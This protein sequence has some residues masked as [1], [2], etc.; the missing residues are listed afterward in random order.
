MTLNKGAHQVGTKEEILKSVAKDMIAMNAT[1]KEEESTLIAKDVDIQETGTTEEVIAAGILAKEMIIARIEGIPG[2]EDTKEMT[3]A[4]I[5]IEM[6]EEDSEII[7]SI[8]TEETTS[9]DAIGAIEIKD[10]PVETVRGEVAI[11]DHSA[12]MARMRHPDSIVVIE[13]TDAH[14]LGT[15]SLGRRHPSQSHLD[16]IHSWKQRTGTKLRHSGSKDR[17][18]LK[19]RMSIDFKSI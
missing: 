4:P 15:Q 14:F 5:R 1:M 9:Q 8:E 12:M 11:S 18:L 13:M 16:M 10:A 17:K 3:D 19:T 7:A 6:T 2:R